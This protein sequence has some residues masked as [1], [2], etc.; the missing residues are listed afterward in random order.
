MRPPE[1]CNQYVGKP[2]KEKGRGPDGYDC[3]G[4]VRTVLDEMFSISGLPD[5]V[6]SYTSTGDK[7][8]VAAAVCA[9]LADGWRKVPEAT[10]GTLVILKLAGRPWHCA[11]AV[12]REWMLHA[13]M[14]S[15]VCLERIDSMVWNDRIEGYYKRG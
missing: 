5:Y 10:A 7:H 4:L 6:D 8:S 12:N 11:I 14:G 9:G 2:F 3:W 1:W 13:V 15:N